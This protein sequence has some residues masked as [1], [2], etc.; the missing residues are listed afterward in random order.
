MIVSK[1]RNL[2]FKD[3]STEKLQNLIACP[4]RE[5]TSLLKTKMWLQRPATRLKLLLSISFVS[6]K[7]FSLKIRAKICQNFVKLP[8]KVF[9]AVCTLQQTMISEISSRRKSW[10]RWFCQFCSSW[11]KRRRKATVI[12]SFCLRP[13][14]KNLGIT[15]VV[16]VLDGFF[17]SKTLATS[18]SLCIFYFFNIFIR[19]KM[20]AH[21][22]LWEVE[23]KFRPHPYR[24]EGDSF[25][26]ECVCLSVCPKHTHEYLLNRW[27]DLN[28]IFRAC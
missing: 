25:C 18:L 8:S 4:I 17:V 19:T 21:A 5:T 24:V 14:A 9:N 15:R 16:A 20:P 10:P 6:V 12:T 26:M 1:G 22:V 23:K 28:E 13:K 7:K 27:T 11:S 3:F 2:I